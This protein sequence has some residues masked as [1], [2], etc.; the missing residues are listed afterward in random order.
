MK[1]TNIIANIWSKIRAV[2][3]K[4]INVYFISGMCYNCKV[5]DRLTLPDGYKKNYIEWLEPTVDEPLEEYSKRMAGCIDTKRPFV[6][7]GYSF[8]AVIV[9]E[10]ARMTAP[11]KCII[12]S[13]FKQEKEKP[14]MFKLAHTT[15][16]LE[17]TPM[18]IYS[19]SEAITLFFNK[20]ICDAGLN[21]VKEYMTVIDPIYVKWAALQIT[22][23]KPMAVCP[24]I[25]HIH[26]TKDQIFPYT[27][28]EN[29]YP[30]P[31]GDHLM[32]IRKHEEV[33]R[34]LHTILSK[35]E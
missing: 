6:L 28:L 10:I 32:V 24:N 18:R 15:H 34:L 7:V 26:G 35:K 4:D 25:Y 12:I 3:K 22:R 14:A 9:Q 20:Y 13:S 21:E 30:I 5:F 8:G 33:S 2:W 23:W 19:S 29:V 27:Q 31:D 17:K 1:D 16:I 11:V